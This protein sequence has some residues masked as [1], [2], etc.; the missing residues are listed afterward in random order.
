[1]NQPTRSKKDAGV[2]CLVLSVSFRLIFFS[3]VVGSKKRAAC[4]CRGYYSV[5]VLCRIFLYFFFF[6]AAGHDRRILFRFIHRSFYFVGKYRDKIGML[7]SVSSYFHFIGIRTRSARVGEA[8]IQYSF[9]VTDVCIV[10]V[11]IL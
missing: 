5:T 6:L 7:F 11:Y 4:S 8:G 2:F 10:F 3:I 9:G 1:M